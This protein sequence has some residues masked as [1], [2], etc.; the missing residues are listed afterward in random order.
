VARRVPGPSLARARAGL[1]AILLFAPGLALAQPRS[2][3]VRYSFD[4]DLVETGPDTFTVFRGARGSVSLSSAFHVSGYGAVELRDVAGDGD[5]P[6]LQGRFPLRSSGRLFAHFAFL[7]TDPEEELN[8]ALAGPRFF[9]MGKD[10]IAFWLGIREGVLVHHSDSIRK[11]LLP[12]QAFVWYAADLAYDIDAGRYDLTIRQEGRAEPLVTLGGQPNA[13]SQPGS[14]VDKFSFVGD[15]YGDGS[16]VTYYVDDV[17]ISTEQS[18]GQLPFVAPGRRKL[19]VHLFAEY[20][21]RWRQ[22]PRCLPVLGPEDF[23]LDGRELG[24][25]GADGL[26]ESFQGLSSLPKD[27]RSG[28]SDRRLE[29]ARDWSEGCAALEERR[30]RQAAESFSRAA[31][32]APEGRI[33]ELSLVLALAGLGRFDEADERLITIAAAWRDD[34]RYALAAAI[35]GATRGDL[36]R[37]EEWLRQP[38]ASV[39]GREGNPLLRRLWLGQADR[40]LLEE[41]KKAFPSAW[42][43][44]VEATLVSEQYYFVLLWKGDHDLARDYALRMADRFLALG[45]P[46]S[47]WLERAGDAAFHADERGEARALYEQAARLDPDPSGPLLKLSDLAFLSGDLDT[48]RALRE[49]YYGTLRPR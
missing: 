17:V 41:L 20:Q 15:P 18:V 40:H 16:N 42:R 35:V 5:F 47:E 24:A 29:A 25:S 44:H 3:L 33:H 48:E 43:E 49:R 39:L 34:P 8:I 2:D 45:L 10:G 28:P 13:A 11:R 27:T 31:E 26:L 22:R 32:R 1:A 9:Q 38:A 46:H 30:P 19:F 4:D 14:A 36:G 23:G 7:T 12:V 37:A 21:K 6:E